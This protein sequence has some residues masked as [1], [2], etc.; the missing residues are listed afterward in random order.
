MN[1]LTVM[2]GSSGGTRKPSV[3]APPALDVEA[4]MKDVAVLDGVVLAL[5]PELARIAGARFAV[6]CHVVVVG[7]RLGADKTLL[8][9]G[10]DDAGGAGLGLAAPVGHA[11]FLGRR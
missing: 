4:E 3:S 11:P 5:E 1:S 6:Q 8:E 9:V 2:D 7:D 10:M